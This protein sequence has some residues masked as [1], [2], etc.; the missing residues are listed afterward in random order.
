MTHPIEDRIRN[1]R[2][3]SLP[4]EWADEIVFPA[5]DGLSL[6]NIPHTVAH[7]LG[8]EAEMPLDSAVWNGHNPDGQI[9]RVVVFLTDGL[10]YLWLQQLINEDKEIAQL[11]ADLTHN[12]GPVPLTSI[13][14]STT[15]VALPTLWS[16]ASPAQHG[17]VGTRLFLR[18]FSMLGDMLAFRP[19]QGVHRREI[20][21]DWGLKPEE[22]LPVPTLAEK[23]TQMDV[24]T[25]LLLQKPLMKSGLSL[26]MHRGVNNFHP[27]GG[28]TDLWLR[29]HDILRETVRQHCF[30]SVYWPAIDTESHLHGA[31]HRYLRAEVKYQLTELRK[32]LGDNSIHDGHTLFMF[33]ADHGHH[34]APHHIDL[35][36]DKLAEPIYGAMRGGSG[37]ESRFTYLYL[38]EGQKQQVIDTVEEHFAE[39]LT[40]IDPGTALEAGLF[41]PGQP[42]KETNH[43]LGDL[44]L[45]SRL[46]WRTSEP[47]RAFSSVSRHGGLSEWEMLIPLIWRR[48]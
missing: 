19:V 15:A 40:W 41:G 18:E 16:G 6:M 17:M 8:V 25:H 26:V 23:L 29:L 5:Y 44:I 39:N 47:T 3:L 37:A 7:L 46:N 13:A 35:V 1:N 24:P 9:D 48:L 21:A 20:F 36:E 43:R 27:I 4:V 14:P 12:Y 45:I 10:G 38:R 2:M 34:D 33:V 22:F 32:L 28:Y 42:Y 30:I 31:H 11:I